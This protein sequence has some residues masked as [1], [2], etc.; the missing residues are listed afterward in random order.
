MSVC[1]SLRED[2]SGTTRAIFSSFSV[3]VVY[4]RGSVFLQHGDEI[5]RRRGSFGGFLPHWQYIV[6]HSV[7]P[8]MQNGWSDPD[9]V[10]DDDSITL[11]FR[12]RV[13]DGGPDLPKEKGNLV[14]RERS[15]I[16]TITLLFLN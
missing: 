2:I 1:L 15:L 16:S 3:H 7:G 9:T 8:H 6:Q 4:G 5:P 13:L 14:G 11:L 12:Y 10:W